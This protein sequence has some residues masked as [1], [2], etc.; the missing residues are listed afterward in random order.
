MSAALSKRTL[1]GYGIDD[2][3]SRTKILHPW[4]SAF[5][6]TGYYLSFSGWLL[7][8]LCETSVQQAAVRFASGLCAGLLDSD[9]GWVLSQWLG[10]WV[11]ESY[12]KLQL[13]KRSE[14]HG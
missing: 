1:Q 7:Y 12:L 5:G 11:P 9:Y 13:H 3:G 6:Q 14:I 4:M 8:R 2:F 10:I